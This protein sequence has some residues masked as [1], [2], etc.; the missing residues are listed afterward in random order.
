MDIVEAFV[1]GVVGIL[2]G[3]GCFVTARRSD[4]VYIADIE[5]HVCVAAL[6]DAFNV[7]VFIHANCEKK[8]IAFVHWFNSRLKFLGITDWTIRSIRTKKGDTV[9]PILLPVDKRLPLTPPRKEARSETF[10]A[11]RGC[12]E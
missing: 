9:L 5:E 1:Y 3:D 11:L 10:N 6:H 12:C 8:H 4:R 7:K 2:S